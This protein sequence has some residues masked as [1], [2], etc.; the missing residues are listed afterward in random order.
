MALADRHAL[1]GEQVGRLAELLELLADPHAPTA[2][3]D[4]ARAVDVHFA[5]SLVAV[6]LRP[7]RSARSIADLGSGAGL[8]GLP[9][10][11]ALPAAH[12]T[13]VESVER[14][15][16]F[17]RRAIE[18]LGLANVDVVTARA[19][20]WPAGIGAHDLVVARALAAAPVVLEYAAPLL[21]LGGRLV[22]WRAGAPAGRGVASQLGLDLRELRPVAP[23]PEA[24]DLRLDVY[25]KV[26]PTPARFPRRPG[27]ARKS[28]LR[29]AERG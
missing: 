29:A 7:V 15:A 12:V 24:R 1:V 17:L 27:A 28:P 6:D 19:E 16:A 10:A 26:A 11:I 23:Y 14:K 22:D 5:D 20:A 21:A 13:L 25:E 4:P 2:V 9:L 3:H 18:H 8:P